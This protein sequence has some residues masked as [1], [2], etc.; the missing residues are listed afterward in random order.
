MIISFHSD[1]EFAEWL[2]KEIQ[3][4]LKLYYPN[5]DKM[6]NADIS[7]LRR[8]ETLRKAVREI[9]KSLKYDETIVE[10]AE[11]FAK[12]LNDPPKIN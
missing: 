9:K 8:L 10:P 2:K 4:Y 11:R 1:K 6:K 5:K 3:G 7:T 12:A